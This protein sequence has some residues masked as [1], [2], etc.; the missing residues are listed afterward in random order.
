MGQ[1]EFLYLRLHFY[2]KKSSHEPPFWSQSRALHLEHS[3]WPWRVVQSR[4]TTYS[5]IREGDREER[6]ADV[7]TM[8]SSR[9]VD[10][11]SVFK[12]NNIL[13]PWGS[14]TQNQ[15][16]CWSAWAWGWPP[17]G[18]AQQIRFSTVIAL[19]F[20]LVCRFGLFSLWLTWLPSKGEWVGGP[21]SEK[22]FSCCFFSPAFDPIWLNTLYQSVRQTSISY[23]PDECSCKR[24]SVIMFMEQNH[25]DHCT[26][27]QMNL[28]FMR[29]NH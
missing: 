16:C 18:N 26:R 7:F 1:R 6:D 15:R 11:W 24:P 23:H 10:P 21:Q 17:S 19:S 14:W 4:V 28:G 13:K 12:K 2:T 5:S 25:P 29:L 22:S 20:S 9:S 3:W 27:L 8:Y